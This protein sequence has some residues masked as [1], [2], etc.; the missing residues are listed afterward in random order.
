MEYTIYTVDKNRDA[1]STRPA[2][3]SLATTR[4]LLGLQAEY[5]FPLFYS[6]IPNLVSKFAIFNAICLTYVSKLMFSKN[7]Q[8]IYLY[9]LHPLNTK[10]HVYMCARVHVLKI[11]C[12][13]LHRTVLINDNESHTV[14]IV[15]M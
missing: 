2:E 14:I 10:L 1:T 13:L 4:P 7:K 3:Y 12:A 8:P 9:I 15:V 5:F 6:K 11:F